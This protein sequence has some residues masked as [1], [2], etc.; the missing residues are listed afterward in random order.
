MIFD[1]QREISLVLIYAW[2]QTD[3]GTIITFKW[4]SFSDSQCFRCES[5]WQAYLVNWIMIKLNAVFDNTQLYCANF[6]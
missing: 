6:I 1:Y 2:R 3:L 5:G 4:E